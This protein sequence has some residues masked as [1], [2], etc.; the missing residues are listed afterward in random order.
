MCQTLLVDYLQSLPAANKQAFNQSCWDTPL[1]L[2]ADWRV[3]PAQ[4]TLVSPPD[5]T[6]A[7]WV[8]GQD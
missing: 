7:W 4:Y 8:W 6:Q 3:W 2:I 5:P 1:I